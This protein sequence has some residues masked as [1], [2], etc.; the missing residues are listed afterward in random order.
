M[1]AEES[2]SSE[3]SEDDGEE[4]IEKGVIRGYSGNEGN[5]IRYDTREKRMNERIHRFRESFS[6]L[7]CPICLDTYNDARTLTCGHSMCWECIEQMRIA[8]EEERREKGS[9][10]IQPRVKLFVVP[11]VANQLLFH[12]MDYLS[13][14]DSKV[15]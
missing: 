15:R 7:S 3:Y 1:E 10:C 13:T 8:G 5:K 6:D 4:E 11:P 9:N 12:P 14:T 2:S